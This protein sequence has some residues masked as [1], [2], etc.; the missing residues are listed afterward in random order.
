MEIVISW[1]SPL[2]AVADGKTA[3]LPHFPEAACGEIVQV[4]G[5]AK[6]APPFPHNHPVEGAEVGDPDQRH[7]S[8]TKNP[9]GFLEYLERVHLMLQVGT[10]SCPPRQE[11]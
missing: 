10:A 7:T 2:K 11:R 6:T 9:V 8:G 5:I 3:F 1:D 4:V